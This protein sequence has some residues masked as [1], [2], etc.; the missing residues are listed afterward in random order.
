MILGLGLYREAYLKFLLIASPA[1]VL[2]QACGVVAPVQASR[3]ATGASAGE[4]SRSTGPLIHG[5]LGGIWIVAAL[6]L[7]AAL[8]GMTLARYYNDPAAARDDYRG[9]AKFI[10]TTGGPGDAV[11]LDAPGQSEVF[12]YYYRGDLPVYALPRQRP[13][14][15]E[16]TEQELTSLLGHNKVY[17]VYWASD[18]A[19]PAGFIRG[20]LDSRG[21]K[22]LDQ[23]RGNVQLVVYVMPER[24]PPDEQSDELNVT[25]GSLMT[26]VG[27]A[28]WNIAP[29]SG[30]VI[31]IGLRWRADERM[32]RRYKVSV[33][34]LDAGD[35]VVAQ[36]D[37]EPAGGSRPTDGW[38]PGEEI[39][40]NHGL[41]IPPGTPPGAY[42]RIVSVY[43][44]ETLE[45]LRLAD[46]TDAVNLPPITVQRAKTMPPL[47]AFS[48][49]YPRRFDFGAIS[50]LGHDRYK[51][52]FGH[53]PATPL[54]PGDRLHVTFYWQAN[55]TPRADWWFDLTLND[56][57]GEAVA[58][59]HAP[60]VGETYSTTLWNP[61][62]V[63]RGEHDLDLS[64]SLRPGTYRLSLTVL[65]DTATPAG[66]AYL[67]AV[68]VEARP[69]G[70]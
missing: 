28:G 66:T 35:Q 56:E 10:L 8:S 30:E 69:R 13:M 51:R 61:G 2:L 40:D 7:V 55:A 68:K 62:D 12:A 38:A 17:A 5:L 63:V 20:W 54:H 25:L 48:I 44:A 41:L 57:A 22:T 46:G 11:L 24:R 34:L 42:R 36:H 23:W 53:A 70:P 45:R 31:Q 52:G 43:D 16:A 58:G 14:D 39:L 18:E 21:Y 1:L 6:G 26:L 19:D 15:S 50:L 65:P 67:G 27:Y 64:D 9:I 32:A 37:A 49:M 59:L 4:G 60:L 3:A 33:Q 47:D 29:T